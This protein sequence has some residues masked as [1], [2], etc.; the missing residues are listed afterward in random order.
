[1]R[2]FLAVIGAFLVYGLVWAFMAGLLFLVA[3]LAGRYDPAYGPRNPVNII[4]MWSLGPLLG[5]FAALYVVGSKSK[6]VDPKTI[7]VSFITV[8]VMLSLVG[9]LSDVA[10][11]SEDRRL[12]I[13]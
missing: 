10:R 8:N 3:V 9:V 2:A 5:A 13:V 4:L 7:F 11:S 1:M 12:V 6:H